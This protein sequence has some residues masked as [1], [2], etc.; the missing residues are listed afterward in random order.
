MKSLLLLVLWVHY[1]CILMF[2]G[3]IASLFV[4]ISVIVAGILISMSRVVLLVR[5]V[6][7]VQQNL[8][9]GQLYPATSS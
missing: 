4:L 1:Q 2:R 3:I 6:C 5:P 8:C 7:Y 9:C